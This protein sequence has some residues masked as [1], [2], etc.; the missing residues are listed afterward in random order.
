MLLAS[1]P[2]RDL[3][4]LPK[5]GLKVHQALNRK[6]ARLP[7][8]QTRNVRLF[9]PQHRSGLCLRES[10]ILNKPVDSQRKTNFAPIEQS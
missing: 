4:I 7:T 8:Y 10:W 9:D 5:G 2:H 1:R 6:V 3:N